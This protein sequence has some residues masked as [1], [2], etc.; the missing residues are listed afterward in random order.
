[1]NDLWALP[2]GEWV[3]YSDEED[4]IKDL[5]TLS[6]LE[7]VTSYHGM[8][9]RYRAFQFKFPNKDDLL[10]YICFISGFNHS[11][12]VKLKKRPGTG[13]NALFGKITHQPPLFMDINP[14]RR[15]KG[16]RSRR[17]SQDT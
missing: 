9:K 14:P 1:M 4:I 6:D 7:V 3:I 12:A 10:K 16:T 15:K 5:K 11:W 17:G 2:S 13:Y 8:L